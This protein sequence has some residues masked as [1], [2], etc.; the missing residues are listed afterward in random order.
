[1][2]QFLID[3]TDIHDNLAESGLDTMC[4]LM[5]DSETQAYYRIIVRNLPADQSVLEL[6]PAIQ[7]AF[8]EHV[9]T[10]LCRLN[11]GLVVTSLVVE[12]PTK[13]AAA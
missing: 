10:H 7:G 6:V 8:V 2:S 3:P 13:G 1:M 4:W 11:N 12:A 9:S 5:G